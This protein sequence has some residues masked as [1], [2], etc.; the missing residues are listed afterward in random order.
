MYIPKCKIQMSIRE[1][2]KLEPGVIAP[3]PLGIHDEDPPIL[4]LVSLVKMFEKFGSQ[5]N[6]PSAYT[7]RCP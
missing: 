7:R 6:Y 5:Q 1:S 2:S 4:D 3:E